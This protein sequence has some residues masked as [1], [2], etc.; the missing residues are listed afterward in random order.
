[1]IERKEVIRN[2]WELEFG[3]KMVSEFDIM[4]GEGDHE[5]LIFLKSKSRGVIVVLVRNTKFDV[6]TLVQFVDQVDYVQIPKSWAIKI[7]ESQN[8]KFHIEEDWNFQ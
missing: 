1:M 5:I 4:Y 8:P 3:T 2:L 7:L 6:Y